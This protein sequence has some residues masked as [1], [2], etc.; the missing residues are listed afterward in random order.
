MIH[1]HICAAHYCSVLINSLKILWVTNCD[2][3]EMPEPNRVDKENSLIVD[4]GVC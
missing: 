2:W 1:D 3:L 4:E